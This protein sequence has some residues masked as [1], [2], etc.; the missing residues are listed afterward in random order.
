MAKVRGLGSSCIDIPGPRDA[1]VLAYSKWQQSNVVDK[2]LKSEFR[3]AYDAALQDSLDLEQV[4]K[5]QDPGFFIQAGVKRG[6]ACRFV[7]NIKG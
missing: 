2:V 3:K 6:V 5:D 4:Y 1:A 7:S